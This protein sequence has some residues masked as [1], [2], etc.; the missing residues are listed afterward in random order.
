[1]PT[2]RVLPA[3]LLALSG[4]HATIDV[5]VRST[6]TVPAGGL[7]E[8]LAGATFGDFAN[9]DV[10]NSAELKNAGVPKENI[11]GAKLTSLVLTV[12]SPAGQT[13]DFLDEITFSVESAGLPTKEIARAT[14]IPDT[15]TSV[16][17]DVL[18][19]ELAPYVKAPKM[20]LTTAVKGRRPANETRIEAV[21]H[22]E[23]DPNL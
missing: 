9:M 12:M 7:L 1:M 16:S 4:C 18:G 14:A 22:L 11:E 13:L 2:R 23:V 15:A 5:E 19:V 8:Q 10:A 3:L 20:S 6:S 17:L 21:I